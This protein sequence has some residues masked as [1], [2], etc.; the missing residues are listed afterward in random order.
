MSLL[1]SNGHLHARQ[2]PLT[3]VWSESRIIRQRDNSRAVQD[4]LVMQAV[5]GAVLTKAG[6]KHLDNLLGKIGNGD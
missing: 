2:Y 1:L 4:A 6:D 3:V 5:I